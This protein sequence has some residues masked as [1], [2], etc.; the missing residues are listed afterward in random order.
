LESVAERYVTGKKKSSIIK[1][2][3]TFGS[4]GCSSFVI[5]FIITS[6]KNIFGKLFFI[7]S[8]NFTFVKVIR[9]GGKQREV[10]E[11]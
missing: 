5:R 6:E 10:S 2:L 9:M 1:P 4:F 11:H 7:S 8:G 3:S